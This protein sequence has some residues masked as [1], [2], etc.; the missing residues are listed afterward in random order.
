M[1]RVLVT[2]A[3]GNVGRQVVRALSERGIPWR[4]AAQTAPQTLG[5]GADVVALDFTDRST[6]EPA[7]RGCTGLF[8]LRPPAIADT[9]NTLIPLID[10]ARQ[11]R[12]DQIVFL[13]VAG[14]GA[15]PLV[16]HHAVE[17]RLQAERGGWTL[18]RPGFF[19]QNCQDAYLRDLREDDRLYVPAGNGLV[20]F[21]DLYDVAEIAAL[22]FVDPSAH[23]D[24]AYT[25]TGP[26]A[27]GFATLAAQLST[28][29]GRPIRYEPASILGYL[30]HLRKRGMP[31]A[32]AAVQ[33][34]LHV[35]LRFGQA[36]TVDPTLERLLG[37]PGRPA[38]T[39]LTENAPLWA[40]HRTNE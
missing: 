22:A 36:A 37:R 32:Q 30:G 34:V 17:R 16:P 23:S 11:A 19:L 29:L 9:R 25:L 3:T 28:V 31:W 7:L 4:G 2:G 39:Y 10:V 40:S 20:T 18:L 6:W 1:T 21:V 26:E 15:N 8:L 12:V 13:S 35:G 38:L 5:V 27:L 24:Q 14:A 33:T